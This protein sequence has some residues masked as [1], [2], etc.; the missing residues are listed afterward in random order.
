MQSTTRSPNGE[1]TSELECV[2]ATDELARRPTRPADFASENRVLR[3]LASIMAREPRLVLQEL[4]D[5]ARELCSAG[6]AGISLLD[7]D[8]T[9][10]ASQFRWI[11]TSG[12]FNRYAG[13]TMPRHFS[14][15][16]TV[17]DANRL[18][19]MKDPV[20]HFAYIDALSEPVSEVLLVPF[21]QADRPIG[22]VWVA[23]HTQD[24][25][26]DSE[27]ARLVTSLS[28]FAAAAIQVIATG[29]INRKLEEDARIAAERA[30][31]HLAIEHQRV[32]TLSQEREH[33]EA[34]VKH[35]EARYRAIIEASPECVMI[36]GRDGSL[37]QINAAGLRVFE[38]DS[39]EAIKGR[40]VLD[41]IAPEDRERVRTFHERVCNGERGT[42]T[43]E[44]I[45]ARG[46]RRIMETSSVPLAS[47]SGGFDRL[48][49][50]RD[51]TER[52]RAEEALSVELK[53]ASR[54]RDLASRLIGGDDPSALYE[55]ILLAAIE[56]TGADAG[57]MQ[58]LDRSTNTLRFLVTRGFPSEMTDHFASVDAS[59]DSPVASLSL[60]VLAPSLIFLAARPLA[61]LISFISI[62]DCAVR[63][64][65]PL[66]SR[67]GRPLG[68][69]STHWRRQRT[70]S[71]REI[72]F[73]DLLGR[74]AADLIERTQA[75]EA[76]READRRKDEFLAILAHE[77]R[78][79]LVPIRTGIDL[80]SRV[81]QQPELH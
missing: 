63:S 75:Q 69:F 23:Q 66:L 28:Q 51:V 78:N 58:L 24:R 64:Q 57:T 70:L 25:K 4:V 55:E 18:L 7:P 5:S 31:A 26:F 2:I 34:A 15:C 46:T 33:A 47:T 12:E 19:L 37:M 61:V 3:K 13:Q 76:L 8:F 43:F 48:A 10:S 38:L 1:K 39:E 65:T 59:S 11:A 42:L 60:T 50:S 9:E 6:S 44:M 56:I 73:L 17:L 53:D 77:L 45:G 72:R 27:D 35:S 20:R 62:M 21:Y 32:T 14:P 68:M 80:L 36:I 40:S 74:Q 54:L 71:E 81:P 79:P 49:I 41:V 30:F 16:G 22:T 29:D 67:S 52:H